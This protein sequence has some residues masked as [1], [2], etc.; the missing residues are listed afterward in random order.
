MA[1]KKKQE[2]DLRKSLRHLKK[3]KRTIVVGVK[4]VL[5]CAWIQTHGLL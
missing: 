1:K 2:K 3:Q 4:N 5:K